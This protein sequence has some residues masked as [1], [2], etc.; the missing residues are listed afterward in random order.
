[1][2]GYPPLVLG[3]DI[4]RVLCS[5]STR[6]R[7]ENHLAM[8]I[9][10]VINQTVPPDHLTLYDDNDSPKD[11][12]EIEVYLQL[13]QT[14]DAKGIKWDV[15]F[16]K[17]RGQHHNH[18]MAN[19]AGYDAVWRLDDDCVAEPEVLERL[20]RALES[21]PNIGAV[22]GS[23]LI[24]PAKNDPPPP[25]ASSMIEDIDSKPNRQWYAIDHMEDV[26]HLHCSFLYRTGIANY[27]LRLSR[28]AHREETMFTH[29]MKLAGYR[30]LIVPQCVTWHFR[31]KT[32]GIRS[33]DNIQDYQFDENLFRG[34]LGFK[35]LKRKL[36]VLNNGLGDHYMFLQAIK[37]EP[38]SVVA[39]C[40][41]EMMHGCNTMSIADAMKVTDVD[42]YNVYKWCGIRKWQG[43]L[44]EAFKKM[45]AEIHKEEK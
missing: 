29:A 3:G 7:Y 30:V 17:K 1:M 8:A 25:I 16:G 24:P 20:K 11:L 44:I 4:V 6:N 38:E 10:S 18:Q 37:P 2:V 35:K 32:G 9:M 15:V 19:T 14:L 23:I 40:Y 43:T 42:I 31:S 12:R 41:P 26:D 39:C 33:D 13:F 34:W 21:S 28:K 45:Y 22:G 27:D 36:Y 5:I